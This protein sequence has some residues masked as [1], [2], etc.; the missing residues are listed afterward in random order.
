MDGN[1]EELKVG[2]KML[3]DGQRGLK[4]EINTRFN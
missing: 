2:Q 4:E 1:I 3:T